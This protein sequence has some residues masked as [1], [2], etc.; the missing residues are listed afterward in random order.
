VFE[1]IDRFHLYEAA[2]RGAGQLMNVD[3][4]RAV[5]LLVEHH[6]VVS[7]FI[8]GT[9]L[10]RME[11]IATSYEERQRWRFRLCKY[12]HALFVQERKATHKF[13]DLQV[14]CRKL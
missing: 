6:D 3:E 4:D 11:A 5:E 2:A 9:Q 10:Q 1:Y 14:R 7:S 12:L 8:V 13:H